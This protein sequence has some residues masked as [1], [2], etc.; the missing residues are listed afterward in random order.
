MPGFPTNG[1]IPGNQSGDYKSR[2]LPEEPAQ[3]PAICRV[4]EEAQPVELKQV[5]LFKSNLCETRVSSTRLEPKAILVN[6]E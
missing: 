1:E 6:L 4:L 3:R 5:A 2:T